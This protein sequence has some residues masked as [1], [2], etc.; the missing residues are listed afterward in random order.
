MEHQEQG[1]IWGILSGIAGGMGKYLYLQVQA[2]HPS[3]YNPFIEFLINLSKAGMTALVC[4]VLGAAGKWL[5]D[6]AKTK[7]L[8]NKTT[9]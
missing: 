8:K 3:S 6:F 4:G 2:I 9:K 7:F 5:F 1:K